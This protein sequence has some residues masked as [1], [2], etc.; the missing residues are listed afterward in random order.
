MPVKPEQ[1]RVL[2]QQGRDNAEIGRLLGVSREWV[3]RVCEEHDID[4]HCADCRGVIGSRL[5]LCADCKKKRR[6]AVL[7]SQDRTKLKTFESRPVVLEAAE[8]FRELGLDVV[9]NAQALRNE[10]ELVVEGKTVKCNRIVPLSAG[11]QVRLGPA[12][13]DWLY[14]GCEGKVFVIPGAAVTERVT[15][16]GSRHE[17]RRYDAEEWSEGLREVLS[18]D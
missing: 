7:K 18:G 10:A 5:L 2:K 12:C 13:V 1:V 8:F 16:I 9:V 3:R 15:Y 6:D 4:N 11:Y 17:F 14:L